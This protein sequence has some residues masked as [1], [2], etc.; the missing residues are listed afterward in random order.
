[1]KT[2]IKNKITVSH[3]VIILIVTSAL[4]VALFNRQPFVA[5]ALEIGVDAKVIVMQRSTKNL[6]IMPLSLS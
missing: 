2:L 4:T 1:M 5:H 6:L 3:L